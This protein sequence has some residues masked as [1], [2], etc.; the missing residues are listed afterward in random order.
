VVSFGLADPHQLTEETIAILADEISSDIQV[1]AVAPHAESQS[2]LATMRLPASIRV[3][4]P[5][6]SLAPLLATARM[7]VGGA[8]GTSV[9]RIFFR[10]PT[11]AVALVANQEPTASFLAEEGL[12]TVVTLSSPSF[13]D[14]F[15]AAL[16]SAVATTPHFPANGLRIDGLGAERVARHLLN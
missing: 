15:R 8:G 14:D 12:A 11:I 9:E 10:V 1:A 3:I 16:R 6:P 2:R 4:G 5:Q 7:A 13:H